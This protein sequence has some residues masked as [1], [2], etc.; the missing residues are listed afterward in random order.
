VRQQ[1]IKVATH[2]SGNSSNLHRDGN[3][4]NLHI[5]VPFIKIFKGLSNTFE[6]L[7]PSANSPRGGIS[8]LVQLIAK[9][10]LTHIFDDLS[11]YVYVQ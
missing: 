2:R 4:L 10:A 11:N 9:V 7:Y 3:S 8:S 1:L 5:G 6:D